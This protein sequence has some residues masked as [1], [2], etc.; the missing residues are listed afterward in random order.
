MVDFA[1]RGYGDE[2]VRPGEPE[3]M[4]IAAAWGG[5]RTGRN[6]EVQRFGKEIEEDFLIGLLNFLKRQAVF[7]GSF[8]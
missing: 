4:R 6:R 1:G 2:T 8:T 5:C 7:T 3:L